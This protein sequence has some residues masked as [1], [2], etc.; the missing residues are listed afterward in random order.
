MLAEACAAVRP[1]D[2]GVEESAWARLDSLTKPPRSLGRLEELAA[3]L[4]AI[5]GSV[6]PVLGEKAV[7]VAAADHGVVARGVAAYPQ[8]VTR[9]M[10]A[11]FAAGGAAI[12]AIARSVGARLV[13]A[14]VGVRA[15]D[16][17]EGVRDLRVAAG[18]RDMTAGPAMSG[19]E[20]LAAI[21]AGIGLARELVDDGVG[22]LGLGEM[23]IGNTTAAAAL[24]AAFAGAGP[25][26]VAGPG[27]GLDAEGVARKAAVVRAALERN[28][29][30]GRDP[31]ATLAGV[32]GL[33]IATL[34]GAAIGA[35][36]RGCVTVADGFVSTAAVVAA[37][38]MCPA[39]R[40]RVVASHLSPEPGH[41][42]AL[43]WLALE[44]LLDLRMR[45][46]EGTGAA[47]AM[48]AIEAAAA[49]LRDMASFEEAGV[50]GG[51]VG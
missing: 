45:L 3:R 50:S 34:A 47:L 40:E 12:N 5:T 6:P 23:G 38:A 4:S 41:A 28:G 20:A 36:G 42:V 26:H 1:A 31:L 19:D 8:E 29:A 30:D 7:L 10:T 46:G 44:P 17:P 18:T 35:A 21:C 22:V 16:V 39:L 11:N 32:G 43:R 49:V 24:V 27:T 15:G 51:G 13:V 37:A 9:Q 48:P 2:T 14:D 25:E 33:E